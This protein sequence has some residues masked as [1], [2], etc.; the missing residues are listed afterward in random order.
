MGESLCF[1]SLGPNGGHG[2]P[3]VGAHGIPGWVPWGPKMDQETHGPSGAN[4]PINQSYHGI[5]SRIR[6]LIESRNFWGTLTP[7]GPLGGLWP[8]WAREPM[9]WEDP[10]ELMAPLGD[11]LE[12]PC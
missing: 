2:I 8:P 12:C 6:N 1:G 3:G 4:F 9:P 11:P 10:R 7:P 5:L